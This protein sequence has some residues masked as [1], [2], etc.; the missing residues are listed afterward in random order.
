MNED[1]RVVRTKEAIRAAFIELLD[2]KGFNSI[3]VKDITTRAHV[4]R[5]TFYMHYEDKYDLMEQLQ[6]DV[7][8]QIP[9]VSEAGI[10]GDHRRIGPSTCC[11]TALAAGRFDL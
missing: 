7:L 2:E 1:M 10:H 8:E 4:N 6:R 9:T 3:T 11:F 5:S